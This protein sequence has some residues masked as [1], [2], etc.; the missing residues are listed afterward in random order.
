MSS[1]GRSVH[2]ASFNLHVRNGHWPSKSSQLR[3]RIRRH[4]C[5]CVNESMFLALNALFLCA[6]N[7][8]TSMESKSVSSHLLCVIKKM[9]ALTQTQ[10]QFI[11]RSSQRTQGTG[12]SDRRQRTTQTQISLV[13]WD[14]MSQYASSVIVQ[15]RCMGSPSWDGVLLT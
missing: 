15:V 7:K 14:P 13:Q 5:T 11:S 12:S 4:M 9:Y 1:V 6:K 8:S 2:T 3:V 10:T